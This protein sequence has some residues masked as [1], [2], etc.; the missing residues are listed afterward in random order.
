MIKFRTYTFRDIDSF[1]AG[2][3]EGLIDF[4]EKPGTM[5][6]MKFCFSYS[7]IQEMLE[8]KIMI[9]CGKDENGNQLFQLADYD[10][11][12][13]IMLNLMSLTAMF[14]MANDIQNDKNKK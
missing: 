12:T 6:D 14:E 4:G 8:K 7:T 1:Q 13:A 9:E 10:S 5:D 2:G 3:L 11:H